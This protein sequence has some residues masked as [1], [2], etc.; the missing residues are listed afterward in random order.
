MPKLNII[1]KGRDASFRELNGR[2]THGRDELQV[3]AQ[4]RIW[5]CCVKKLIGIKGITL[6]RDFVSAHVS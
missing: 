5:K 3:A 2:I 1:F 4:A 6:L